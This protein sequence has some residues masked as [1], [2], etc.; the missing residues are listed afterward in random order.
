MMPFLRNWGRLRNANPYDVVS[1]ELG[2]ITNGYDAV[3]MELG[4]TTNGYDAISMELETIA[5][6]NPI[7]FL[8]IFPP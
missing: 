5:N 3:S 2:R 6:Y 8:A 7:N 1:T 4:R